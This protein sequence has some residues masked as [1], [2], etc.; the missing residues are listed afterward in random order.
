[1][2]I[3][4]M[5]LAISNSQ[6]ASAEVVTVEVEGVVNSV[7][8]GGALVLDGS[9]DT[10]SLMTGSCIYDTDTPDEEPSEWAGIYRLISISVT[11]GNY[12]FTR[13][14]TSAKYPLFFVDK[15]DR[16]YRISSWRSRFDGTI[17]VGGLP[18]TY[19][20]IAWGS[21]YVHLVILITSSSEAIPTDA[22]PDLD[23]FPELSVFDRGK[24]FDLLFYES[25]DVKF[26]VHGELTYLT[27]VPEPATIFLL[28][29]GGLVLLRKRKA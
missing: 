2:T 21:N 26:G 16:G 28:A 27:A 20:D 10:G 29:F 9:V 15:G 7:Y 17:T 5:G 1:M 6:P 13:D 18:K 14:P 3:V 24:G 4:L 19:E 22:L 25:S 12:T 11:I 8:T 23:S